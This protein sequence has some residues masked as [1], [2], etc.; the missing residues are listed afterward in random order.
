MTPTCPRCSSADGSLGTSYAYF[1]CRA[2]NSGNPVYWTADYQHPDYQ[3]P[4]NWHVAIDAS[5]WAR[6]RQQLEQRGYFQPS[7]QDCALLIDPPSR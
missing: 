4:G 6:A 5:P 3:H 7:W 1:M 2:C